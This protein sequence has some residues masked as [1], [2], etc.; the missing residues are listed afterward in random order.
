[1]LLPQNP[2]YCGMLDKA[3]IA[4]FQAAGRQGKSADFEQTVLFVPRLNIEP[5]RGHFPGICRRASTYFSL[6]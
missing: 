1:M 3:N 6:C 2:I 5:P 4:G